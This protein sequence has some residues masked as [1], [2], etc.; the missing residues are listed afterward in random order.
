MTSTITKTYTTISLFVLFCSSASA[1]HVTILESQSFHPAQ[2]MDLNWYN[3][4]LVLGHAA[5]IEPYDFLDDACNLRHTDILVV[6]S[7]LIDLSATQSAHIKE[8]VRLGGQLYLQSE[9]LFTHAGN[10]AFKYLVSELGGQFDWTGQGA[11]QQV[12]MYV[13][14]PLRDNYNTVDQL[15]YF[16][17][18]TYG[19]GDGTIDGGAEVDTLI[20]FGDVNDYSYTAIGDGGDVNILGDGTDLD[21][22]DVEVFVIGGQTFGFADLFT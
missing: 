16:W 1:L 15:N 3:A 12:P 19:N 2:T 14:S 21:V 11:G 9:Y 17:Y 13:E 10:L 8:F 22:F 18:G 20:L 7:G 4:A 5:Q 6:S